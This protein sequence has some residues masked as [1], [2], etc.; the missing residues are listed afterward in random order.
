MEGNSKMKKL[1]LIIIMTLF[2]FS[3]IAETEP[4]WVSNYKKTGSIKSFK[5]Y[6]FGVGVSEKSEYKADELAKERFGLSLETRVESEVN[7]FIEERNGK[8]TDEISKKIKISSDIGLKGVSFAG[9]YYDG[10][11]YYSLIKYKKK[12]YNNILREEVERDLERQKIELD[13]LIAKNKIEEEEQREKIRNKKEKAKIK[14]SFSEMREELLLQM[15]TKYPEYFDSAPPYKA[16][17]FRNG[18]LIPY[19]NQLNIKTGLFPIAL[20]E[21]MLAYKAWLF[22][23]S[24]K[25][26]FYEN[27]YR[28][29]ELQLKYQIMPY[30]GRYNKFSVAFGFTGYKTGLIDSSFVDA[31]LLVTPFIAG[32][33]TLPDLYFSFGSVYAD[34][35]KAGLAINNYLFY[36]QLKDRISV[37]LEVNYIYDEHLRNVFNDALVFQPA[38]RFKTTDNLSST[39]S[40]EDNQLWKISVEMG[41]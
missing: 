28:Q 34:L 23:L 17:S 24:A 26:S 4:G 39:F 15:R 37:I 36:K 11:N 8:V 12:E 25:A 40:Y 38:I 10:K 33:V 27:K 35:G 20:D 22:E 41:F 5:K 13:K 32:N 21:V 9:R 31:H 1:I 6:Y 16:V 14:E 30:S 18:Q 7:R 29:Q 19:G 2:I 3:L